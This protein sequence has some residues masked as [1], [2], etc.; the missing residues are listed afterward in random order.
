[1]HE[2]QITVI[3]NV[4]RPPKL[5]TVASGALVADFRLACTPRRQDKASGEWAD[6]ETLWFGITCWRT[7]ADNTAASLTTGDRVVVTGRLATRSWKGDD[8]VERS[9][10]EIEASS[11]GL[12]LARGT[13]TLQRTARGSAADDTWASTGQVDPQSGRVFGVGEEPATAEPLAA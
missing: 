7:L 13:A 8:G 10:L 2:P 5:R 6:G 11:I 1:M 12:D 4:A 9:S 3:G